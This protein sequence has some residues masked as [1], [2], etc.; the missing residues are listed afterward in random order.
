VIFSPP[1]ALIGGNQFSM[2]SK[3]EFIEI[4]KQNQGLIF[5]VAKVYTNSKD[6]GQDLYQEIVYQLWKSFGSFKNDAKI[7]TWMYRVAMNTAIA[8]LD[9]AKKKG[10]HIPIDEALLNI[11]DTT[12][13]LYQERS[14]ALYN[15]IKKLNAIEKGI[16]LL[17]L[18]GKTY[19]EIALIT[20]FTNS[21]VGTRLNR[22][23]QKLTAQIN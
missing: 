11:P 6:D 23:K 22:I 12:D 2:Q 16:V 13:T 21:N 9:K 1:S 7:T 18:E 4:I 8:H 17:Y 14:E 20:G 5:K 10:N 3:E 19:D 15:Q